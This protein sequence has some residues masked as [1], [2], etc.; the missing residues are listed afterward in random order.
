MK[1][2][3]ILTDKVKKYSNRTLHRIMAVKD[4]GNIKKGDLGG[5][6][7]REENL[8]QEGTC[9]VYDKAKVYDIARVSENARIFDKAQ[10]SGEAHIYGDAAVLYKS[11]I[12][13][14]SRVCENARI[15]GSPIIS[16]SSY[17]FGNARVYGAAVVNGEAHIG[18]S[19]RVC[20]ASCICLNALILQP[21]DVLSLCIGPYSETATFFKGN[22]GLIYVSS[23]NFSGTITEFKRAVI[24]ATSSPK[25]IKIYEKAIELAEIMIGESGNAN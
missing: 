13:G 14:A 1:K 19:A 4:F 17:I 2:K 21:H 9:W 8:S 22:D 18:G 7:E 24:H 25:Q 3:Y 5:W 20:G 11:D 16:G 15:Y 23:W 12:F 10:V 6:I